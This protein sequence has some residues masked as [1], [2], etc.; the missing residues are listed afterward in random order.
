MSANRRRKRRALTG[1][2]GLG[3]AGIVGASLL[4]VLGNTASAATVEV[5]PATDRARAEKILN[6]CDNP[7]ASGATC[8]WTDVKVEDGADRLELVKRNPG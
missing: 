3:S 6:D 7:T 4:A 1:L 5:D 8:T 2:L